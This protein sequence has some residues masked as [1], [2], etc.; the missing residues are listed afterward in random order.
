MRVKVSQFL[1]YQGFTG[2]FAAGFQ[3]YK[4]CPNRLQVSHSGKVS[5]KDVR[6][7]TFQLFTNLRI[8]F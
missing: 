6:F 1:M 8:S 4:N 3:G 5:V 2:V 7:F